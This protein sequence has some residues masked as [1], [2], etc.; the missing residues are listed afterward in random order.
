MKRLLLL[1]LIAPALLA[2]TATVNWTSVHQQ[3][4]GFGASDESQGGSM[5]SSCGA[6]GFL[7]PGADVFGTTSVLL[8]GTN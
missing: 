8:Y 4:D 1:F 5:P 7:L 6:V 2:Q 3:I